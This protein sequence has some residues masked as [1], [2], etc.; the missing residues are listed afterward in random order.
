MA[1]ARSWRVAFAA[2]GVFILLG[3][4]RH[5]RGSMAEM[6]VHPDWVWSHLALLLGFLALLMGQKTV[7]R[8]R[9]LPLR[10][11]SSLRFAVIGTLL[12]VSE[13]ALHTA[14]V[15]D[16]QKLVA[17]AP[18]P[19]LTTHLIASVLFYPAFGATMIAFVLAAGR[20]RV[21]GSPWI[22]WI[23]VIGLAAHGLSAPLVLLFQQEWA[24]IMFPL[25]VLFGLWALLAAMWP[26]P[27]RMAEP[28]AA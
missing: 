16:A 14:A 17:G 28:V 10:T 23:G 7:E 27:V 21:I 4:P 22:S 19:V 25:L 24:G 3:A 9:D 5:P 18:T 6:L 15:V 20:D 12:Q 13:M 26:V 1:P 11:R 2:T 8:R